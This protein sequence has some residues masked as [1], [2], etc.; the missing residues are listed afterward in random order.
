[1]MIK[2]MHEYRAIQVPSTAKEMMDE[3]F[4]ELKKKNKRL[5]KADLW[6]EAVEKYVDYKKTSEK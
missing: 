5:R 2:I 4:I 1:M 3:L 6:M